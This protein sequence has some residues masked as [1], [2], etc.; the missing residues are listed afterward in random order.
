LREEEGGPPSG[1]PQALKVSRLIAIK[2]TFVV[3]VEIMITS[4]LPSGFLTA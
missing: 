3:L 4:I 1:S 2:R